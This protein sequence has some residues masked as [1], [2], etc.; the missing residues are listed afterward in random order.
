MDI[1]IELKMAIISKQGDIV[2]YDVLKAD[3]MTQIASQF[4]VLVAT[5]MRKIHESEM[6]EALIQR[7]NDDDDIP[8]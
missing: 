1:T 8:F 5:N 4:V 6:Q 2:A 7:H 3:N